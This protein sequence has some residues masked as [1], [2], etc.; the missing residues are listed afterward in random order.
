V[1]NPTQPRPAIGRG[2]LLALQRLRAIGFP[3]LT[4]T[5]ARSLRTGRRSPELGGAAASVQLPARL[6]RWVATG[7]PDTVI[8]CVLHISAASH[9]EIEVVVAVAADDLGI[10]F[11][12]C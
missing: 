6:S 9:P 12:K 7:V 10:P 8:Q 2:F 1:S 3:G 4:M 5:N 11:P